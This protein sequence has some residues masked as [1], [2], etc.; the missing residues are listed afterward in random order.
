MFVHWFPLAPPPVTLNDWPTSPLSASWSFSCPICA[1][2]G[3]AATSVIANIAA[4]SINFFI[5]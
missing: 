1:M 2:A 4:K 3:A 5:S